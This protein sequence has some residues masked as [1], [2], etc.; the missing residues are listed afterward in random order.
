MWEYSTLY[1]YE[2][3][4]TGGTEYDMRAAMKQDTDND[5]LRYISDHP[6]V[7]PGHFTP[8]FNAEG[9]QGPLC[10]EGGNLHIYRIHG[11]VCARYVTY[12]HKLFVIR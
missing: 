9:I 5:R 10:R 7:L 6:Q 1:I 12:T 3:R 8:A 2:M 4:I 11:L